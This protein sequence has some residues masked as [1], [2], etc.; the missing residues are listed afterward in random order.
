VER[1]AE[2]AD[3]AVERDARMM[4]IGVDENFPSL[5]LTHLLF[6]G[7]ASEQRLEAGEREAAPSDARRDVDAQC[8]AITNTERVMAAI[9]PFGESIRTRSDGSRL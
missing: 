2:A 6:V 3:L 8:P 9:C 7:R 1:R 5:E 4:T